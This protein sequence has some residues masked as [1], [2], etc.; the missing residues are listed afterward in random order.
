M[1]PNSTSLVSLAALEIACCEHQRAAK[2]HGNPHWEEHTHL[3]AVR[4]MALAQLLGKREAMEV[5]EVVDVENEEEEEMDRQE[6]SGF[7]LP[8]KPGSV[9]GW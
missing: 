8:R 6:V 5:M 9:D 2:G 1:A 4:K 7:V 3:P